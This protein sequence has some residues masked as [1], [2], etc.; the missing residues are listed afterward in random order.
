[1]TIEQYVATGSGK[2][3]SF[4]TH[5]TEYALLEEI[6]TSEMREIIAQYERKRIDAY[7]EESLLPE[8]KEGGYICAFLTTDHK[9][10]VYFKAT[11]LS[12]R[13]T[14]RSMR[15]KE[16]MSHLRALPM[17]RQRQF[18]IE[19]KPTCLRE[20]K[21]ILLHWKPVIAPDF[22]QM[23]DEAGNVASMVETIVKSLS[24]NDAPFLHPFRYFELLT[25]LWEKGLFVFPFNVSAWMTPIKWSTLTDARY[26]GPRS[27][28]IKA[29]YT[30]P[31]GTNADQAWT[32]ACTFFAVSNA[33]SAN[34]LSPALIQ[35]FEEISHASLE[36]R[37]PVE[38]NKKQHDTQRGRLRLVIKALTQHFNVANPE[39]AVE[40]K[41]PPNEG[42][43]DDE[44]RV[45]GLFRWLATARPELTAWSQMFKAY[46][47]SLTTARTASQI[48]RLNMLGDYLCTLKEPPKVPWRVVRAKHIYDASLQNSDTFLEYLR[49]NYDSAK[50]RNDTLSTIRRFF[51]WQ[52][53]Y[54][55][56][57]GSA[58]ADSFKNPVFASD[59]AGKEDDSDSK[60]ER[61]A[62]PPY[63]MKELRE[64]LTENDFAFGRRFQNAKVHVFDN[65][66]GQNTWVF[67]PT[68]TV[69][70][71][72]LFDTP[73]RSHQ[74]RWLD[75]GLLDERVYDAAIN[76]DIPNTSPYAL[77]GRR[78]GV[79]RLEH[80][81]LRAN[82][83][84]SLWINTN[85]TAPYGSNKI[86]YVIPY[87]SETLSS[88]L[89][90]AID[91]QKRYLHELRK[92]VPYL[93]YQKDVKERPRPITVVTPTIAP[94]FRDPRSA[95]KVH[96]ISYPRLKRFYIKALAEA[97]TRI[98]KKYG[99]KLK[100]V[101][102]DG[103][104]D[105]T[106][107]VDL[108]SLRV[109][110]I[111]NLIDAGVP[112]EVVQQFVAGHATLVM[113]LH[114]LKY[115]PAKLRKFLE[116]AHERMLNDADFVG[117]EIFAD[118]L[119]EFAPFMLGQEGAGV[120]A[121]MTAL[122][123]KTGIMTINSEGICPGTSCSNGGPL[124]S[125]AQ[126]IYAPVPGGQRC[127]LCRFWLTGPA[128]LLG[129]VAAVNNLAYAIRKKGL[130]VANLNDQRIDAED[131][132]N[133]R[134]AREL[135]DRVDILNRELEIDINEWAARYRYAEKS[136][137]LMND[138]LAAKAKVCGADT[139]VPV[140]LLTASNPSEL[141]VTLEEA[142]E[143]AL[144]DQITQ[145]SEFTTGFK[146]REAELEKNTILSKM[147]TANGIQPFL[148]ML[149]EQQAHEAGNLLSALLLQ[150]VRGHELD[151][152][153]IGKKPLD[154]YPT[155]SKAI[156]LLEEN[157]RPDA[158]TKSADIDSLAV[159]LGGASGKLVEDD[160][161]EEVFG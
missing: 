114:Y 2:L 97:Q 21:Q 139:S 118:Y 108:H 91:W 134:K 141:K 11:Y 153:L 157:S 12:E 59:S 40:Y 126:N 111:T 84:L 51:D 56:A 128:H 4:N 85:K 127:G 144:L 109:S 54:L 143:F 147:L 24:S 112:L 48:D 132:G 96:P 78:E 47:S 131:A 74:A 65:Q 154:S 22:N 27:G 87:V 9:G 16:L 93:H 83:W 160:E 161:G 138:Y 31:P 42:V 3:V 17:E 117:S 57:S 135:C 140:P 41:R 66:T 64:L 67:D 145:M 80:D 88:L 58:D 5:A 119:D 52:H 39:H 159:A 37:Y 104:G 69:C 106:W 30:L 133:Q 99:R 152:V 121:G 105:L 116:E 95:D 49:Q 149:N 33:L 73:I 61:D 62:L 142:H 155:L 46:V 123:D 86:G 72:T 32:H 53:D 63:V 45:D 71:Y 124:Q 122:R 82:A 125:A 90:M 50:R 148:L 146:N 113:T 156:K 150:Q 60:T 28:S 70:L 18:V 55:V 100:L 23:L 26:G 10:T 36:A 151:E 76:S 38:K 102:S 136:I 77:R 20:L 13:A 110:G 35:R 79:L 129:Q 94:L 81:G 75:S 6:S 43:K 19:H 107:T 89:Q 92:P 1:M 120:G 34:D 137:A 115:S 44:R 29:V 103:K 130:E 15:G 101:E 8:S 14:N 25:M 68:L 158:L 98:E 7:W